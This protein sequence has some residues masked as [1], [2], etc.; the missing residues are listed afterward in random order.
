MRVLDTQ[1]TT[2]FND[3]MSE[4][5]TNTNTNTYGWST[6]PLGASG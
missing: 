4:N 5:N 3:D 6:K 2:C 1:D